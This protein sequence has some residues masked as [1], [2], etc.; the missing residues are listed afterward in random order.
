MTKEEN[1]LYQLVKNTIPRGTS[2]KLPKT[3]TTVKWVHNLKKCLINKYS[4]SQINVYR[5]IN[6]HWNAIDLTGILLDRAIEL[7]LTREIIAHTDIIMR[8]PCRLPHPFDTEC[9]RDGQ[10]VS[11]CF[12]PSRLKNQGF[13]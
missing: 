7:M 6:N 8:D 13:V 2:K 5:C 11:E 10:W 3:M 12:L 4:G 9:M 1:S